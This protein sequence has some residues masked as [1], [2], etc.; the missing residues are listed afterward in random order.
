MISRTLKK[1]LLVLRYAELIR[2]QHRG[3]SVFGSGPWARAVKFIVRAALWWS[4]TT[5]WLEF[6]E[7]GPLARAP[8][9]VRK[10]LAEKIHRPYARRRHGI[11][12]KVSLLV[13][14]YRVLASALP[15]V[16][17]ATVVAGNKLS[18][19]YLEGRHADD[20]YVIAISRDRFFQQ[21]GELTISLIDRVLNV[22]LANLAMNIMIDRNGR[23]ALFISG[24]QGPS[25]PIGKTEVTQATRSLD[26]L[27]PKQ[28]VLEAAYA[29]AH[30]LEID[31]IVATS[32]HNHVS[33]TKGRRWRD[34]RAD[35]DSFWVEFDAVVQP[36]GDYRLPQALPRRS[37]EEVPVKRRKNWLRR[38]ARL[39]TLFL[40]VTTALSL[41]TKPEAQFELT[42]L[43]HAAEPAPLSAGEA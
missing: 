7:T 16:V 18:L 30:W 38:H 28:A 26:G 37:V 14:H 29:F 21:Q 12:K 13:D 8:D 35:Y 39:K 15:P 9:N 19:A 25:P 4:A 3:R 20:R 41:L 43:Q 40:D 24:L 5:R 31:A 34:I 17:L 33:R 11:V 10:G 22:S 36:D 32:K 6:I 2:T 42:P 27:R 1:W 23:R